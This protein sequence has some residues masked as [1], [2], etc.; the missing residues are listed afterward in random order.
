MDILVIGR[1]PSVVASGLELIRAQGFTAHG[2]TTDE[3]ALAALEAGPVG[4]LLIGGGLERD[5]SAVLKEK[6]EKHGVAVIEAVRNG[7]DLE[8][9]LREDVFPVLRD[10][11]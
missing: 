6:A 2:V 1:G 11:Q 4:L 3:D 9:Y 7:R 10:R 8:T 5:S